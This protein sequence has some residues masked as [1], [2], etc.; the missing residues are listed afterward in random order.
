MRECSVKKT[1]YTRTHM[2]ENP[3]AIEAIEGI[4]AIEAIEAK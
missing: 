3:E 4:K 2:S 1:F